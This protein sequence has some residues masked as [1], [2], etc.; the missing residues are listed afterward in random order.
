[1]IHPG[2]ADL[3]PRRGP[4]SAGDAQPTRAHRA[5]SKE[6]VPRQTGIAQPALRV[7]D[8]QLRRST[9]R[10]KPIPR[11]ADFGPLPH[12]VSSQPNPRPPA[13]FQPQRRNL[14]ESARQGGRKARRLQDE[15]LNAGSTSQC[16]Q[17]AETLRQ[18]RRRYRGPLQRSQR[19]IQQQ[20]IDGSILEEHRRH[21]QRF[22]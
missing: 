11:N 21:R 1:L 14:G 10:R 12:H 3:G 5:L 9:G 15:Q 13:Q 17:S 7:Q 2:P 20:Q 19:Q 6:L 18:I 4:G 16:S 22:L 8:P